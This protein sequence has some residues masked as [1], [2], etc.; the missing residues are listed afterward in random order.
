VCSPNRSLAERQP[1]GTG[2]STSKRGL[3]LLPA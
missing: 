3:I 2:V 1:D